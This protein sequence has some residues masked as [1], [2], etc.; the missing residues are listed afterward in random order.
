MSNVKEAIYALKR[1]EIK[2]EVNLLNFPLVKGEKTF[3]KF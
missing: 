2:Y 1:G 3:R